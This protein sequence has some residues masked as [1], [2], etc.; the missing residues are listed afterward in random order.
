MAINTIS[1]WVYNHTSSSES[2]LALNDMS[3]YF[4]KFDSNYL[5]NGTCETLINYGVEFF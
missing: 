5:K 3:L 1:T 2:K 4:E